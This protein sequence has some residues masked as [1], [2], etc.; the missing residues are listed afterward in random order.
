MDDKRLAT[1]LRKIAESM[2]QLA[3]AIEGFK[4]VKR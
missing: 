3:D 4:K 1:S 2:I